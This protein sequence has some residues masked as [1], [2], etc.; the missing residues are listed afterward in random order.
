MGDHRAQVD[1]AARDHRDRTTPGFR[2]AD[3]RVDDRYSMEKQGAQF[4][5]LEIA[6]RPSDF[7]ELAAA[8]QQLPRRIDRA[9]RVEDYVGAVGRE[10]RS[11]LLDPV[12][13][14][15]RN[16]FKSHGARQ[17]E[18]IGVDCQPGH[19][20]RRDAE[21]A[22]R[23]RD[24]QPYRSG[25][26]DDGAVAGL[27]TRLFDRVQAGAE[28]FEQ[29][30]LFDVHRRGNEVRVADW[31]DREFGECARERGG[32]GAKM[33]AAGAARTASP[34]M[35]EWIER[36]SIANFEVGDARAG[37]EDFARRLVAQG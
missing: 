10:H 4:G 11:R 25:S 21:C 32:R 24:A 36:D 26:F 8:A 7:Y 12:A 28:R 20:Y 16:G 14:A 2:S 31:R 18:T 29:R 6:R 35:A 19:H 13:I 22:R 3:T 5:G 9:G 30:G 33:E 34:A 23:K 1:G 27:E 17:R 15:G 37:F